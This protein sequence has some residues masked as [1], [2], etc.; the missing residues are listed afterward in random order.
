MGK[1]IWQ[2]FWAANCRIE[3][4][5]VKVAQNGPFLD[6]G[7][8]MS[9]PRTWIWLTWSVFLPKYAL[10]MLDKEVQNGHF[11]DFG[12]GRCWARTRT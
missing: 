11:L 3:E 4:T 9:W 1:E 2:L 7:A 12:A 10:E 5:R 8:Q 6:S